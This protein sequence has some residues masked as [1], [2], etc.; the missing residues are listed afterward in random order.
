MVPS[1]GQPTVNSRAPFSVMVAKSFRKCSCPSEVSHLAVILNSPLGRADQ[2]K[3]FDPKPFVFTVITVS[4]L[5]GALTGAPA[6]KNPDSRL[7]LDLTAVFFPVC[8][9]VKLKISFFPFTTP[10]NSVVC[11]L[12]ARAAPAASTALSKLVNNMTKARSRESHLLLDFM[13]PPFRGAEAA[14]VTFFLSSVFCRFFYRMFSY[15]IR[16]L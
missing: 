3:G 14:P 13:F 15:L 8:G 7:T 4:E 2:S 10:F 9:T 16:Y 12:G 5:A 1:V 11:A 6:R